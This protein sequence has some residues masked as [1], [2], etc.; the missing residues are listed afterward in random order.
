MTDGFGDDRRGISGSGD[1]SLTTF[2]IY[3]SGSKSFTPFTN[4]FFHFS[5]PPGFRLAF[6][7]A[8]KK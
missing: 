6:D 3:E 7:E 1:L 4:R 2:V 8:K 5:G